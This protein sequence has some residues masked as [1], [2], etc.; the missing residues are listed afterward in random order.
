MRMASQNP[1]DLIPVMEWLKDQGLKVWEAKLI[2]PS[3][4]DV[5]V[6]VTGI[7]LAK[8]NKE[9]EGRGGKR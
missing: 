6:R 5:F 1:I 4:E 2:Q 8:M 7:E 9:K 3:L